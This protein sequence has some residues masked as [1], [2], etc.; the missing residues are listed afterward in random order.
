MEG[1][2]RHLKKPLGGLAQLLDKLNLP[3]FDAAG[4]IDA[5][6]KDIEAVMAANRI[7][8]NGAQALAQKQ[9]EILRATMSA[10]RTHANAGT[11]AGTPLEVAARQRELMGKAFQLALG[12]MRELAEIVRSAQSDAFAVVKEQVAADIR[13]LVGKVQGKATR[14]DAPAAT[15]APRK[16][17]AAKRPAVKR[18][19]ANKP[20]EK[21]AAKK[22]AAVPA[23]KK[24]VARKKSASA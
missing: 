10:A 8:Y 4:V 19:A 3:Q 23:A 14:A 21:P 13:E 12:H 5:R 7:V 11:F 22:P 15:V 9:M 2:A 6:R 17:P 24:P 18:S 16:P 1:F 20:V